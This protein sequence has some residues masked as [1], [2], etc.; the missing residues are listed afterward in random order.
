MSDARDELLD[1]HQEDPEASVASIRKKNSKKS[2]L[3]F[4]EL[5]DQ[6]LT[7]LQLA[8]KHNRL[9]A[10]KPRVKHFKE[11]HGGQEVDWQQLTE[12][13][14]H[15]F[16]S[17][18]KSKRNVSDRTIANHLV[19]IRTIFNL[20]IREGFVD[21][22]LYPFGRGRIVIRFPETNKIG[23]SREEV[24]RLES[25]QLKSN[26]QRHALNVWLFSF[27]TAGMRVSDVLR[28]KWT[29]I[30][31]G[32]LNY[33]MGKN[34]K[35]LSLTLIPRALEIISYYKPE[36]KYIFPELN[37]VPGLSE[38]LHKAIKNAVKKFNTHLKKVATAAKIEKPLNM[39]ISRHT[40][41]NLSAGKV[42]IHVLQKLYRHTSITTT[43]MYQNNF[44]M[45]ELDEN[46]ERVLNS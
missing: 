20:A 35:A 9:S 34:G 29:D 27:Y 4:F 3:K 8:G 32:R 14:I 44:E 38:C 41:G 45:K 43:V 40:F 10:D 30:Q 22:N 2:K 39:H 11:F 46:L 7:N 36:D 33:T 24:K 1:L 25:I 5:A 42:P 19:V 23:L 15:Q 21:R 13:S 37:D 18:L 16:C 12:S 6:Y 28:L 17:W 26:A 31:E